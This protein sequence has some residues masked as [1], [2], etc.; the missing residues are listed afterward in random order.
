MAGAR[1]SL[2]L[3]RIEHE[4]G[5]SGREV[6]V[7][8]GSCTDCGACCIGCTSH[9]GMSCAEYG[10]GPTYLGGC[11]VWPTHPMQIADKPDCGF[12]FEREA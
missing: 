10:T 12:R 4:L 9:R 8:S 3:V 11:H 7:R 5:P 1:V 6:Y 2:P